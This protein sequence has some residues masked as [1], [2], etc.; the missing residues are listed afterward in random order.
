MKRYLSFI[1]AVGL[2]ATIGLYT[3]VNRD[4]LYQ[5]QETEEFLEEEQECESEYQVNLSEEEIKEVPISYDPSKVKRE[6]KNISKFQPNSQKYDQKQKNPRNQPRKTSLPT[7]QGLDDIIED[8]EEEKP[9][10]DFS[11]EEREQL[12]DQQLLRYGYE[13]LHNLDYKVAETYLS[14]FKKRYGNEKSLFDEC[15]ISEAY[16]RDLSDMIENC[17]KY[18]YNSVLRKVMWMNIFFIPKYEKS[19][20]DCKIHVYG[21][22][23]PYIKRIDPSLLVQKG[24]QALESIEYCH[25]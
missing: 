16:D 12:T 6:E 2:V 4:H 17:K 5:E 10:Y 24:N 9:S 3:Y 22:D 13:A 25:E 7:S 20:L 21:D 14:D 23:S 18:D 15:I 1:S 19:I 11:S 8:E